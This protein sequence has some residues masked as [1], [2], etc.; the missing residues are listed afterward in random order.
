M[1]WVLFLTM[2]WGARWFE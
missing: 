1:L 2:R